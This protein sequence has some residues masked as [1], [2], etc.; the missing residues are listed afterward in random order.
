MIYL[1]HNATTP[2]RPEVLEAMLPYLGRRRQRRRAR[3]RPGARRA[4]RV[5]EARAHD[6]GRCVGAQPSEIVFTSGGTESNNLALLGSAPSRGGAH[7][8]ASP[9]EHASVL[10]P[11]RELRAARRAVTWLP[12]DARR[13]RSIRHDV[14]AALRPDTALVSVGWANNEIGTVQPIADDRALSA[15]RAA[16]R[17]TSTR[18]RRSASC[19]SM[20]RTSICCSLSAHKLGGPKGVGALFVRRGVALQPLL[21]A[22]SR[23]A[24]RRPA[25]RTSPAIVGFAAA[26]GA[27][28]RSSAAGA[29]LRERLWAG[30]RRSSG[31]RRNSPLRRTACRTR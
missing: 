29:A 10:G 16:S 18:C 20:S 22:A 13:A 3:T 12:V 24:G 2:L 11:V 8:V 19:R 30:S 9:I 27:R 15:A 17:C 26:L 7:V 31:V 28:R 5:E 14:A 1:D 25:P 21:P 6:R 4:R 23:S